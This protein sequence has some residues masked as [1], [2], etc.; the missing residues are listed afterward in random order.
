MQRLQHPAAVFR[1]GKQYAVGAQAP[2]SAAPPPASSPD[3]GGLPPPWFQGRRVFRQGSTD[4]YT[5]GE[6]MAA[7]GRAI[8]DRAREA[9]KQFQGARIAGCGCGGS[10]GQMAPVGATIGQRPFMTW[11][12]SD[13]QPCCPPVEP[14]PCC[15]SCAQGGGCESGCGDHHDHHDHHDHGGSCGL[16]FPAVYTL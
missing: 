10:I 14:E 7:H 9:V 3:P 2:S 12:P 8:H 13:G 16:R 5:V 11:Q 15:G 4:C 1:N 6:Q